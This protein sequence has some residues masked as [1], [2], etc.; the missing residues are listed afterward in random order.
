MRTFLR[1]AWSPVFL[2]GGLRL[3]PFGS[4]SLVDHTLPQPRGYHIYQ[5]LLAWRTFFLPGKEDAARNF[6]SNGSLQSPGPQRGLWLPGNAPWKQSPR[7]QHLCPLS[8]RRRDAQQVI[9]HLTTRMP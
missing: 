5:A 2:F 1:L 3:R 6:F 8:A 9:V 7:N 4:K